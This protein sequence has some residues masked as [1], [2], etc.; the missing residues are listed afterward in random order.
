MSHKEEK[1]INKEEENTCECKE[2]HCEENSNKIVELTLENVDLK[3]EV[4]S[5]NKIIEELNKQI[6]KFNS[7]YVLKLQA[8]MQEANMLLKEKQNELQEKTNNEIKEIKKYAIEKHAGKIIDVINQFDLALSYTPNDEKLKNYQMGFKMFLDMFKNALN[9]MGIVEIAIKLNDEFNPTT[10]EAVDHIEK[11]GIENGHVAQI[12]SKGY[13][14]HDR[15][16][17]TATV[18]LGA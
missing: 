6:E 18:K 5:K 12:I 9:D 1:I 8:K 3:A 15:I 7:D 11:E 2:C 14:L 17:Q 10:M 4:T 13:K 16:I